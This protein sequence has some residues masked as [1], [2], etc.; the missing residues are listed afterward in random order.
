MIAHWNLLLLVIFKNVFLWVKNK[1]LHFNRVNQWC[2]VS[3]IIFSWLSFLLMYGDAVTSGCV[4]IML[5]FVC[6]FQVTAIN[7]ECIWKRNRL[8]LLRMGKVIYKTLYLEKYEV[9]SCSLIHCFVFV[10]NSYL[11]IYV[12]NIWPYVKHHIYNILWGQGWFLDWNFVSLCL[13]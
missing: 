7:I 11:H 4:T 10:F 9:W 1:F 13:H 5:L 6:W 8:I 3:G 12:A 2:D